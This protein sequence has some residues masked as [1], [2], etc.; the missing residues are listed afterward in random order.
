MPILHS[1]N[2]YCHGGKG[3][4][5]FV[6]K[7]QPGSILAEQNRMP[8]HSVKASKQGYVNWSSSENDNYN[9][10]NFNFNNGNTNNNNKNN[11]NYV[12][13]VLDFSKKNYC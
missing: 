12:R 7:G 2:F 11:I 10:W 3:R 5:G 8:C 1:R 9:P 13:G 4:A 6:E